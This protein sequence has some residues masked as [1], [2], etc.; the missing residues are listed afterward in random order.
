MAL[1][2]TL[3]SSAG[4]WACGASLIS[5]QYLLTAGHCGQTSEKPFMAILGLNAPENSIIVNVSISYNHV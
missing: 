5:E 2:A 3:S 1:W 4:E